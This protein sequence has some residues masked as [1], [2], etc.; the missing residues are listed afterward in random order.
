MRIA[1]FALITG[2]GLAVLALPASALQ[3]AGCAASIRAEA[4]A[5]S[6]ATAGRG[7]DT[8]ALAGST[9]AN[10]AAAAQ[11]LCAAGTIRAA[12][13]ASFTALVVR[14]AEGT[15]DPVVYDDPEQGDGN[16]ILEYAFADG[17]AP[18][19]A[20]LSTAI[21][22]WRRPESAGCDQGGD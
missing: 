3:P 10:F 21:R 18:S 15:A 16:I 4:D 9:G 17:S 1:F 14:N 20:S 13:L 2:G 19:E 11:R 8:A 12:E 5:E 6:F 22:C 7:G